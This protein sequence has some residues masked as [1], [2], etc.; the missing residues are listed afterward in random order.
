MKTNVIKT[1]LKLFKEMIE[2][3]SCDFDEE[4]KRELAR[5]DDQYYL[6]TLLEYRSLVDFANIYAD[7]D[8]AFLSIE[9][10]MHLLNK[11]GNAATHYDEMVAVFLCKIHLL[12]IEDV[13]EAE[14]WVWN[15]SHFELRVK[16]RAVIH[17][18]VVLYKRQC[19][20]TIKTKDFSFYFD[21]F[22]S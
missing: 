16:M 19:D 22:G 5:N 7:I 20:G 2:M 21:D 14:S 4:F 15:T 8:F 10:L 1:D 11:G 17:S 6:R 3:T 12:A 18:A 13:I 9:D